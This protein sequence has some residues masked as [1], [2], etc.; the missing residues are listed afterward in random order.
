MAANHGKIVAA[1]KKVQ[2]S[3]LF[4]G[5]HGLCV[6]HPVIKTVMH[7]LW[8]NNTLRLVIVEVLRHFKQGHN[9]CHGGYIGNINLLVCNS[10]VCSED[11]EF[12]T[13]F[14]VLCSLDAASLCCA[15]PLAIVEVHPEARD[16]CVGRANYLN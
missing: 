9:Y 14:L 16:E 12:Q 11:F 6:F 13:F 10:N 2:Q 8:L 15:L 1:M 4:R 5:C 3:I 7:R